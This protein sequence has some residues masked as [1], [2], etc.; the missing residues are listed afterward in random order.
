[1]THFCCAWGFLLFYLYFLGHLM[2]QAFVVCVP[3]VFP[4]VKTKCLNTKKNLPNL[5]FSLMQ[6]HFHEK[7]GLFLNFLFFRP[8][9]KGK[10][11]KT[12]ISQ[13]CFKPLNFV[14]FLNFV[15]LFSSPENETKLRRRAFF[16]IF[17]VQNNQI[18]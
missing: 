16:S 6:K 13:F 9:I 8:W 17:R 14:S 15:L 1:M 3:S 10:G 7:T 12:P 11:H 4:I 18:Y 5:F 2:P